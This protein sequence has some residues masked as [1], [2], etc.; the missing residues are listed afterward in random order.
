MLLFHLLLVGSLVVDA[1]VAAVVLFAR[2]GRPIDP[3]R[4]VAAALVVGLVAAVKLVLLGALGVG[5]FGMIHAVY[6]DAV[7]L[8]PLAG[9]AVLIAP[10]LGRRVTPA[11]RV[12]AALAL[13]PAPVGVYA[14]FIEPYRLQL[15]TAT[16]EL[17]ADRTGV[18]PLRV[19]VLADLQTDHVGDYE[20]RAVERLMAQ[21]PDLVLVPGDLF[22]GTAEQFERELPAFRALLARLAEAP[23]GAWC[24]RGN[25]DV[26]PRF[27]RA[28]AG[29]PARLLVNE[30][31][32]V[33]VADRRVTLGGLD[34]GW[35]PSP[36]ARRTID[37]LEADPDPADIRILIAHRPDAALALRPQTRIDLVVCG[38]THGG[39][40]R[41]PLLGPPITFTRL[42]RRLAAGGLH[43]LPGAPPG[44]PAA[45]RR[46]YVSRGVG[47]ERAH[48]PP[49][50]VNCPPEITLLTLANAR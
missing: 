4:L 45:A 3:G 11:A 14:S 40:V 41:L 37:A 27:A 39:Q 46:L 22:Q 24:C 9:V 26:A 15:E 48:A 35:V 34:D 20:R 28:V 7:V 10:R 17:P 23:G 42:P 13:I 44:Q 19:G 30:I 29:T 50:R 33:I 38:H 25:V 6:L 31:A 36:A 5:L 21:R 18:R 2:R 12:V 1:A 16:V 47:H 43:P 32:H 8:L 49:L